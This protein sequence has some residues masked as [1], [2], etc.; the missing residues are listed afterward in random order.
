MDDLMTQDDKSFEGFDTM[1]SSAEKNSD[2]GELN[3]EMAKAQT[4][5]LVANLKAVDENILKEKVLVKKEKDSKIIGEFMAEVKDTAAKVPKVKALWNK[6][7][8]SQVEGDE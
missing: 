4:T 5:E 1:L 7:G 2:K 6:L 3:I 8:M